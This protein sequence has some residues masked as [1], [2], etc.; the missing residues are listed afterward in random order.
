MAKYTGNYTNEAAKVLKNS[1]RICC[2]VY[3]DGSIIVVNGFV[4]FKMN[5][6]EY[7]AIVQPITHC[8]AGNWEIDRT[9]RHDTDKDFMNIWS[10]TAEEAAAA[11]PLE[12]CPLVRIS[13]K[14]ET[15]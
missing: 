14:A 9:G 7:A 3:P 10:K 1:E 12:L 6:P 15:V 5:A 4:L 8:D 11:A 2:R 13:N